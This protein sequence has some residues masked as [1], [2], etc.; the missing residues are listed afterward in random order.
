MRSNLDNPFLTYQDTLD[1][2]FAVT[3]GLDFVTVSYAAKAA[4]I[5]EIRYVDTNG[6]LIYN[7]RAE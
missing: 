1:M 4:D 3:H 2:D 5:D 6:D 7:P